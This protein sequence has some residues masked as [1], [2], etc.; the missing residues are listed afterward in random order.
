MSEPLSTKI[1]ELPPYPGLSA[2]GDVPISISGVT[3]RIRP[4]QMSLVTGTT[5]YFTVVAAGTTATFSA[6]AGKTIIGPVLRGGVGTGKLIT[7]GTPTGNQIKFETAD[8][9]FT[10]VSGLDF[11]VDEE[12]TVTFI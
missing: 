12:L 9:K 11:F 10:V 2:T 7:S 8:G 1:S 5:D 3:Y 6:L 4:N